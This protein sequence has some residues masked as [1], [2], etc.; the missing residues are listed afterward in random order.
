MFCIFLFCVNYRERIDFL[1]SLFIYLSA[2]SAWSCGW[3]QECVECVALFLPC[4]NEHKKYL[5]L[6]QRSELL[7]KIKKRA[8]FRPPGKVGTRW[9]SRWT[10]SHKKEFKRLW[11]RIKAAASRFSPEWL[12]TAPCQKPRGGY[13]LWNCIT[14][15]K[16]NLSTGAFNRK[17]PVENNHSRRWR[18]TDDGRLSVFRKVFKI[19]PPS[20]TRIHS[21]FFSFSGPGQPWWHKD[22]F[23]FKAKAFPTSQ[24]N[25]EMPI[26][27]RN[28]EIKDIIRDKCRL[29]NPPRRFFPTVC[30]W[31]RSRRALDVWQLHS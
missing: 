9:P 3:Q 30:N 22:W 17:F 7:L 19:F 4:C 28:S 29:P 11:K 2:L 25:V 15:L 5:G 16:T 1:L 20:S 24:G 26:S 8:R 14:I 10:E 23:P 21:S 18:M 27:T 12:W 13:W 31:I 6:V